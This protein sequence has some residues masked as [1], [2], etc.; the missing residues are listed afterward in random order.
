VADIG[1]QLS[2]AR[3]AQAIEASLVG[4]RVARLR[5]SLEGPL[6]IVTAGT[7]RAC[8]SLWA[9][10]HEAA[11]H[12]AWL[13][14]PYEF[15]E[16]GVP[17]G[18]H[19]LFLSR[20]GRHHDLLAAARHAKTQRTPAHAVVSD[21][22][23]P[24]VA[25]LRQDAP[26]NGVLVLDFPAEFASQLSLRAVSF[27][28][29][30]ASMY[31]NGGPYAHLFNPQSFRLPESPI[32]HVVALGVGHARAAALDLAL[33]CRKTRIAPATVCDAREVS[34]GGANP[35]DPCTSW[36]VFFYTQ[37]RAE[38]VQRFASSLPPETPRILIATEHHGVEGG[39]HL[40]AQSA[41]LHHLMTEPSAV[42][43]VGDS[44]ANWTLPLFYL[45]LEG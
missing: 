32:S 45:S 33:R 43:S 30:V 12:P 36:F 40:M 13:M 9:R 31:G 10:S 2:P 4:W 41:R 44:D 19:L 16:R 14:S 27:A 3:L 26:E 15:I 29:L 17:P 23:S 37:D 20:S 35:L 21:G 18:T 25:M 22:R 11:G 7:L 28:V 24:L 42:T 38:Y 1:H 34:H 39:V 8:A 5:A 6:A